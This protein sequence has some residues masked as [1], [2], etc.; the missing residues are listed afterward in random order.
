MGLF[1]RNSKPK[2]EPFIEKRENDQTQE[3]YSVPLGLNFLTPY[4]NKGEATAVSAFFGGLQLI[5]QTMASIP[6][7]VRDVKTGE[8][9]AHPIDS[10]FDNSLQ[11]RFTLIKQLVWDMYIHGN[12]LFYIKRAQDG[13]PVELVYC[14]HGTYSIMYNEFKR[15]LYYLI[16]FITK[17][18]VEP[19][20]VIH[21]LINST[22]GINGKGIP[23][24]AKKL[25]DIALAT[26]S[27][28]K[29]Y[30]ENGANIDGILKSN[31]TLS[32][33]QKLDMKNSWNTVHGPGKN[34]GIAVLGVDTD[35]IPIG[36]NANDSEMLESR[37]FNSQAVLQYLNL[38][39]ILLGINSAS[40]YNSIEQ[41]QLSFLSHCIY[42]LI[43][44][45]ESEFNRKLIKP[46]EK[47]KIYIDLDESHI[48]FAD[49]S[50]TANYYSTLTKNG[51]MSVNEAR[52]MLGLMPKEGCDDLIIPFTD[53]STN[54]VN[55]ET[56]K[57]DE[58]DGNN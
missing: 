11:S 15:E 4:L 35:Y 25:L 9:I 14:P 38:D 3:S 31:K 12:G 44:L 7:H 30:F 34:G 45:L 49:K 32:P 36:S 2:L 20:N 46:S 19:I 6:L 33:Q 51:I 28:A 17:R 24:Y 50:A 55:D 47:G 23:L 5:T 10:A 56:N 39:P 52:H 57:E 29:N 1:T 21:C 22:D 54:K 58:Q 42:P 16:P 41:A 53:L 43:S 26:D 48:Q 40:S 18:R 8:I 37:E 13:T 27:H